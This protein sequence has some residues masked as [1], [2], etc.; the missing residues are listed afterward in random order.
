MNATEGAKIRNS[1]MDSQIARD[2]K[3]KSDLKISFEKCAPIVE[4]VNEVRDKVSIPITLQPREQTDRVY[5]YLNVGDTQYACIVDT[6]ICT[7]YRHE[8]YPSPDRKYA[9]YEG[10]KTFKESLGAIAM[11]AGYHYPRKA[12]EID[13]LLRSHIGGLTN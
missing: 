1:E 3:H 10:S 13:Q 4:F 11:I 8:M 6:E 9:E 12:S 7:I 5:G 2:E